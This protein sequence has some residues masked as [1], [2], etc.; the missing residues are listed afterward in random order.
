MTVKKD[1]VNQTRNIIL[2]E[3][4]YLLEQSAKFR[5]GQT[6]N[7]D[8][9]DSSVISTKSSFRD[10]VTKIDLELENR[11][12]GR[13]S[14]LM[15]GSEFLAEETDKEA[16]KSDKLWIIDPIDGTTN[17][18]HGLPFFCISVALHLA[19]NP[20][21]GF[22][23]A[24]VMNEFFESQKNK[25]SFLNSKPIKV[26]NTALL[27]HSLLATGFAYNFATSSNNNIDNFSKLQAKSRG[28]RRLG[29]AALDICY[30]AKG[31]FDGFWELYLSPWDVAA[32]IIITA[33]AGGKVSTHQN[34]EYLFSDEEIL[35]SNS[36]IHE[37]MI[38]ELTK[39]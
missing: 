9:T 7:N 13:L 18:V 2:D 17:F 28:I 22:V 24:P 19:G 20:V 34:Q 5:D 31:V 4:I 21:L 1:F 6:L 14:K 27:Q 38:H 33:E 3:G 11:L 37:E 12:K 16:K 36:I 23:Y 15:P 26:S 29:S 30:V 32:G 10:L 39:S 35:V 25:G 8:K